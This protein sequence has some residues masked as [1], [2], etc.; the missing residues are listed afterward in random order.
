MDIVINGGVIID[1]K[2]KVYSR[3]NLGIKNGKVAKI[4]KEKLQGKREIDA[5]GLYI[6]PGFIDTHMHEDPIIDGEIKINIF[7]KML[8][9]GVTS[10]LGGN[11]GIGPTNIQEYLEKIDKGN[12][13]N[14]GMFLPHKIL[15]DYIGAE[16]RY[17]PTSS[18]EIE[19][20]YNYGKEII[21]KNKLFG[22]SFGIKY[23]PGTN[24]EELVKLSKLGENKIVS[25]HIR[26]DANN[27][28]EAISEFLKIGDYVDTHLQVS[29]IGSMAGFGQMEEVFDLIN[30][31]RYEGKS[32][33]CDCYPYAAFSTKLGE[34][35][36]DDG[37]IEKYNTTY[38]K[39]EI[40]DGELKGKRCS[41]ESFFKLR[42]EH[43]ET[44]MVAHVMNEDDIRKALSD[45]NTIIASDGILGIHG[46]GHPRA[47]GTFPRVISKY[48]KEEKLLP[49][50]SAIEKMTSLPAEIYKLDRGNLSIGSIGDITI[51]SLEEIE[52]KATFAENQLGPTGI[53]YVLIGGEIAL[54]D[55]E[56][57]NN[58][59]GKT[60]RR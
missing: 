22:I 23:I 57:I 33:A 36:F 24:F 19:K 20:M 12:S 9:M 37:F 45:P 26:D 50:Y 52:D 49:L 41:E 4:S 38:D 30:E 1:P 16:D 58:K 29:H 53:K 13:V 18:E 8:R 39:L 28:I 56:I 32:I 43:P 31:K 46:N 11:C 60:I 15:R 48:V 10:C 3:L 47:A 54:K 35:T 59:L 42:K 5:T 17:K 27:V 14:F 34:T 7:D 21:E 40:A 6:T 51:F 2:N 44:M 55:G 25:A